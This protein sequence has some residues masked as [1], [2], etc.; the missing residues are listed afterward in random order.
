[1]GF[2]LR[3]GTSV[4]GNV[5]FTPGTNENYVAPPVPQIPPA[6]F[7]MV[8]AP[9]NDS[10]ADQAGEV[11][12]YNTITEDDNSPDLTIEAPAGYRSYFGHKMAQNSTHIAIAAYGESDFRGAVYIY[13]KSDLTATPHRIQPP[14]L[15]QYDFF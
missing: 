10:E 14:G 7:F 4:F 13:D 2:K 5:T 3:P 12:V 9:Y 11:Y 8:A 15:N 6:S 1:M